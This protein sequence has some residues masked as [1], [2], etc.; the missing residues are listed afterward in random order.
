MGSHKACWINLLILLFRQRKRNRKSSRKGENQKT[1]RTKSNLIQS[2]QSQ[3][4]NVSNCFWCHCSS[5]SLSLLLK[6]GKDEILG[7]EKKCF[8][9]S[10][11]NT[12]IFSPPHPKQHSYLDFSTNEH[13]FHFMFVWPFY[14]ARVSP[15]N[16]KMLPLSGFCYRV[17]ENLDMA[18]T[19]LSDT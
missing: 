13:F 2:V 6:K 1:V 16:N 5:K 19:L 7:L 12:S 15:C 18:H 4:E 3:I 17:T 11:T 9:F 10:K 14:S 8:F